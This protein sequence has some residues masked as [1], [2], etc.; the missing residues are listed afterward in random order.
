MDEPI[1][2]EKTKVH[3][4]RAPRYRGCLVTV[5][6]LLPGRWEPWPTL[7]DLPPSW[8]RHSHWPPVPHPCQWG[9][10]LGRLLHDCPHVPSIKNTRYLFSSSSLLPAPRS[11]PVDLWETSCPSEC[12]PGSS[13]HIPGSEDAWP[14]SST[15]PHRSL[16][17]LQD[18]SCPSHSSYRKPPSK[19]APWMLSGHRLIYCEA[20]SPLS[21]C[22]EMGLCAAVL[23]LWMSAALHVRDRPR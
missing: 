5:P 4:G 9:P 16:S 14:P 13:Q 10:D 19:M 6:T 23:P 8:A 2:D 3:R 18:A 22:Q 12:L 20:T 11:H 1:L 17:V 21:G 7:Q 15:P